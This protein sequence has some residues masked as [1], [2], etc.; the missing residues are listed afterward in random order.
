MKMHRHSSLF[1]LLAATFVLPT[2]A[3]AQSVAPSYEASPDVYKIIFE[4][5][6]FRVI[7]ATRKA[8]VKDKS[9]SHSLAGVVY[10]VT[11]CPSKLYTPDGKVAESAGRAGTA[12]PTPVIASHQAENVGKSDCKQILVEKK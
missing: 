2:A 10:Y 5:A 7:E 1:I 12:G 9:H 6:N 4:D 8:G 3:T 11:D